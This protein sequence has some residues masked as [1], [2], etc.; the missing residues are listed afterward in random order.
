M[1]E[2]ITIQEKQNSRGF[3]KLIV[4]SVTGFIIIVFVVI[5]IATAFQIF[6]RI[7]KK[8][9]KYVNG[10]VP[11]TKLLFDGVYRGSFNA[12]GSVQAAVIEFTINKGLVESFN[13]HK[14]LSTPG[15]NADKVILMDIRNNGQLNFD[16]VTGASRTTSF[17]RAAIKDAIENGPDNSNQFD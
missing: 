4:I 6:Y 7:G 17:T 14:I 13:F 5:S 10:Y 12:I 8:A 15:N 11:D 1:T 2:T 9:D 3:N 16:A